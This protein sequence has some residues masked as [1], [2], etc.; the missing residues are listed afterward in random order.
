MTAALCVV[1]LVS[2]AAALIFETLW[3]RQSGLALGNTV[4][5]SAL[6][7]ASFMA[8]L[9]IGNAAVARWGRRARRPL[10]AYAALELVVA[11]TGLALVVVIPRVGHA[12]APLMGTLGSPALNG[13][14]VVLAF[15]L[16]L[17]PSS[18]TGATLPLLASALS[19]RDGNFGRVLGRLY[20]WNTFGA[21]LGTLASDLVLI[22]AVGIQRTAMVAGALNLVAAGAAARLAPQFAAQQPASASHEKIRLRSTAWQTL[23]AA[24][25]AGGILLALEVVWFRFMVSFTPASAWTFAA[26]RKSVV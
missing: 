23:A 14:R 4:W 24:F 12:L 15:L 18:A 17:I 22:E 7:T 9:A 20:G 6:V 19:A 1:F 21:F 16:L 2:G 13:L 8:G 25:L 5:A 26:D 11:S 10:L 3:F